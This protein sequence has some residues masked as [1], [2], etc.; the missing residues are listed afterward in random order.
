MSAIVI[1]I[2]EKKKAAKKLTSI[3][4]LVPELIILFELNCKLVTGVVYVSVSNTDPV[5]RSQILIVLSRLPLT[6]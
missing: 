2:S 5:R 3:V 4:L 1:V 6:K